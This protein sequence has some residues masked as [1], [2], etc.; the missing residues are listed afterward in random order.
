MKFLVPV[1]IKK[2]CFRVTGLVGCMTNALQ[3]EI[4]GI[5]IMTVMAG[6]YLTTHLKNVDL[7]AERL[8]D[9]GLLK[10]LRKQYI[11]KEASPAIK[12]VKE[13]ILKFTNHSVKIDEI[14]E[15]GDPVEKISN[16]VKEKGFSHIFL[17]RRRIGTAREFFMGSV[18]YGLLHTVLKGAIYLVGDKTDK[19]MPCNM[20]VCVVVVDGSEYSNKALDEAAFM[21]S[22]SF[23]SVKKLIALHVIDITSYAEKIENGIVPE[24]DA[25]GILEDA[26]NILA[27]KGVDSSI[28]ETSIRY[29]EVGKTIAEFTTDEDAS[30]LFMGR[31]GRGAIEEI[32]TGSIT[33][34]VIHRLSSPTIAIV[35][36]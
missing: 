33:K 32:L 6:S 18:S 23:K 16:V 19:D 5:S 9:S 7:R 14:L 17:R 21:V 1:D 25:E 35:I 27:S 12:A 3:D 15:D 10:E 4:E 24:K 29:G 34:E 30:I 31:K 36:G 13:G 26:K 22:R 28:I 11:E 2:T 20:P 8:L